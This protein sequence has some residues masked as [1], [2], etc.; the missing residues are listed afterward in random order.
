MLLQTELPWPEQQLPMLQAGHKHDVV[1]R[2][3]ARLTDKLAN[4]NGLVKVAAFGGSVTVTAYP[5]RFVSWLQAAFPASRFELV[6]LARR[7][8]AA[9]YAAFCLVQDLPDDVNLVV[10]EF[11]VN[12]CG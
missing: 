7:A 8:S 6:N 10:L 9:T 3:F 5:D 1:G 4:A 12:G 2:N 11:S